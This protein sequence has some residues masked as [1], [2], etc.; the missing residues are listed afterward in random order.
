M[1]VQEPNSELRSGRADAD[2]DAEA[3]LPP[4]LSAH[5]EAEGSA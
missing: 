1:R 3:E 5:P 2:A 4:R